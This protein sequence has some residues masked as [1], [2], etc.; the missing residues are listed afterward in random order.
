MVLKD[1]FLFKDL[2][3][4]ILKII[5]GFTTTVKLKKGNILFYEGDESS[6]LIVL[7]KG[8][9]KLY[10]T[11]SSSK[12]IVLKYFHENELIGEV[13]NF[14]NI[15]YPA[16]AEAYGEATLLKIDFA[17]LKEVIFTNPELSFKIQLS[18]IK[19]IKNLENIVS[20]H[21]VLDSKQ[22]VAKYIYDNED[23]FFS[24]KNVLI[25]EILNITPE[26]LSRVLR[27]FKNEGIIDSENK[28]ID[29]LR[30]EEFF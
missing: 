25:A 2:P 11:S 14:E 10:K 1:I 23:S 20:T 3:D 22:R 24:T 7:V 4:E 15:P 21:L 12:E 27:K 19:K 26:T 29:K 16:T 5:E 9:I 18:L 13:A 8:I 17:K 30:L 6:S 28:K